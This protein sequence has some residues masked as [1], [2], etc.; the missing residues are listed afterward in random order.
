MADESH[1]SFFRT[2]RIANPRSGLP[3]AGHAGQGNIRTQVGFSKRDQTMVAKFHDLLGA[4]RDSPIERLP[5]K[6]DS[7]GVKR[8]TLLGPTEPYSGE[9]NAKLLEPRS[10]EEIIA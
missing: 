6:D 5:C 9:I 8:R 4:C 10:G 1:H 2:E 7:A 3:A